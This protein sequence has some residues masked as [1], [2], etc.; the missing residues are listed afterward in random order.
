MAKLSA[1]LEEICAAPDED[2]KD[3]PLLDANVGQLLQKLQRLVREE[4]N[5]PGPDELVETLSK[6]FREL[7]TFFLQSPVDAVGQSPAET[8]DSRLVDIFVSGGRASKTPQIEFRRFLAERSLARNYHSWN[9]TRLDSMIKT[10]SFSLPTTSHRSIRA[11]AR[12]YF[13]QYRGR[14]QAVLEAVTCGLRYLAVEAVNAFA[15]LIL[16]FARQLVK[17]MTLQDIMKAFEKPA[18]GPVITLMANRHSWINEVLICYDLQCRSCLVPGRLTD[19]W[20][21]SH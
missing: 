21:E 1:T 3:G 14:E 16:A 10:K 20:M 9:P 13:G 2:F 15:S 5:P 4:K 18:L 8:E 12:T 11:F 6:R 19:F 7:N 17:S